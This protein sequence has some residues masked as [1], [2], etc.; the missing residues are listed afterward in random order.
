ANLKTL[1]PKFGPRLK[2]V[3]AAIAGAA[4]ARLAA[5][6]QGGGPFELLCAGGAVTLDPGD[7]VVQQKAPEGWTGVADRGT[8]V[9]LDVRITEELAR[10][11]MARA[12]VRHVQQLRKNSQLEMQD[13]II[14]WLHTDAQPL[15]QAI[16]AHRA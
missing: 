10:E 1:G 6:A 9:L 15:Q 13:R 5:Q 14:L 3:Q 8:Q 7:L 16:E 12:V 2:D 11:G 4:A